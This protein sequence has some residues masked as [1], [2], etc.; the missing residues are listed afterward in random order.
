MCV[1]KQ[2][3][4][5]SV[6]CGRLE[7]EDNLF[8]SCWPKDHFKRQPRQG[9]D[10]KHIWLHSVTLTR[11][12]ISFPK[13]M[14]AKYKQTSRPWYW[15]HDLSYLKFERG[16]PA[17][18]KCAVLWCGP[19]ANTCTLLILMSSI[20]VTKG[21]WGSCK[22]RIGQSKR[23]HICWNGSFPSSNLRCNAHHPFAS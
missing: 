4:F 6:S 18:D 11:I 9:L 2:S 5:T 12:S 10:F 1:F 8:A 17:E 16:F 15:K 13:T 21:H 3:W 19:P 22:S 20:L 23:N 7:V 14:P